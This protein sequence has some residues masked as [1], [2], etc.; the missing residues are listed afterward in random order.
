M[1]CWHTPSAVQLPSHP[2]FNHGY[3]A[4]SP[5]LLR[6]LAS[7]SPFPKNEAKRAFQLR[8]HWLQALAPSAPEVRDRAG[9]P[10]LA[11]STTSEALAYGRFLESANR[12]RSQRRVQPLG[13]R[14]R[15]R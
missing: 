15:W 9:S 12:A 10:S 1:A 5:P 3:V 6:P 11:Q 4:A 14:A 8:L 7:I 2:V 13:R